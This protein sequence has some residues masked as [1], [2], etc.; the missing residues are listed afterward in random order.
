MDPSTLSPAPAPTPPPTPSVTPPQQYSGYSA[1]SKNIK[2]FQT[3]QKM[4][5]LLVVFIIGI[6]L[7]I[8]IGAYTAYKKYVTPT[9][10][11][12][13]SE[14]NSDITT[15]PYSPNVIDP[16]TPVQNPTSDNPSQTPA[17]QSNTPQSNIALPN[18]GSNQ[19]Q[20][21]GMP[22]GVTTAIN[23]I[24][25]NGIKNNQYVAID[26]SSVPDGTVIRLDRNS[27]SQFGPENGSINGTITA[28]GQ[29]QQGSLTFGV[30]DGIWKVVS[31]SIDV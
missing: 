4:K 30:V 16:N 14:S 10:K 17:P 31:Y 8:G 1:N 23:S 25:R 26:T 2:R 5:G 27:W 13:Q 9:N 28:F 11:L 6:P 19:L 24:E 22:P 18:T 21:G 20:T 7:V 15:N 3:T 29:T 12:S